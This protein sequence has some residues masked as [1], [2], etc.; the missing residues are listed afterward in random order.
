MDDF[1]YFQTRR[2]AYGGANGNKL[3]IIINDELWMLKLPSHAQ[4][5]F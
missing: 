5:H 3:S 1:T 2:K 4:K